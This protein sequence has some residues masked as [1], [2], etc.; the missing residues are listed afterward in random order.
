MP[1]VRIT[2]TVRFTNRYSSWM[3][4]AFVPLNRLIRHRASGDRYASTVMTTL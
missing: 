1:I 2:A 3:K 4:A